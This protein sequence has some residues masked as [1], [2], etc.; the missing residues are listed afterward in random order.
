MLYI[1]TYL[2]CFMS[3]LVV[4]ITFGLPTL[5]TTMIAV[6]CSQFD[7]LKT[8]ILDIRQQHFTSH[9]GVEDKQVHINA[10]CELQA[11]LI[12][13]IRHQQEVMA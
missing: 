7:K 11:K 4:G 3:V 8:T 2:Q 9:H 5:V 12:A 6:A 13:C 1:S 10:N